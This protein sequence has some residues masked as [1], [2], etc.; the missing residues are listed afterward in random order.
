VDI[1]GVGSREVDV[2]R[3]EQ[4]TVWGITERVLRDLMTRIS[5]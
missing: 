3:H 5:G 2:F 1:R 4:H